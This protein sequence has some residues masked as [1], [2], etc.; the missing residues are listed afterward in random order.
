[1][2]KGGESG[3]TPYEA[4]DSG[5]SKQNVKIVEIV[6]EGE[7]QGLQDGFKSVYLDNTPV[8]A[9]DD[10]YNFKNLFAESRRGTQDQTAMTGFNTSEKEIAVSKQVRK[11][12][13]LTHTITDSNVTRLRLT[14]GVQSLFHQNDQGDTYG[15]EAT[16]RVTIGDN[17]HI[18]T[19]SG[20]Y[21]SQYLRKYIF[22]DLP[23][24][25]FIVRVERINEDSTSSRLQNNTIWASYTEIID[26]DFS[27]P[28]TALA[29]IK[30]D[31]DYFSSVPSRTYDV[32]GI[33]VRVP[34]NYNPHTRQYDGIWDGTFKTEWTNNPAWILYDVVTSKRYGLGQRLGDFGVDKWALYQA[35]QYCDQIVPDGFG[36]EE[37]RFVCNAWITD[38]KSA[39]NL[40]N[41]ICSIFRAMP[42]WNGREL[43][44][45]MDRPTDPVWTY[46]NANVIDGEFTYTYS[47]LKSRHNAIHVEWSDPTNNYQKTIEY[48]SDDDLI[49]RNGLNVK[50]VKAFGCTS[51]GQA[52]RTGLWILQTEKLETKTVTF[53]VGTEGLMHIP[54]DIIKVADVS[55]AGTDIGGRVSAVNGKVVT[56]DREIEIT[57]NSYFSYIDNSARPRDIKIESVNGHQITLENEPTGLQDLG[58][59]SLTTQTIKPQLFKALTIS[60]EEK[61]KYSILA[62]QHEPQKENIVDNGVIFSA[63]EDTLHRTPTVDN[64]AINVNQGSATVTADT[65]NGS[66][67]AQYDIRIYKDGQLYDT[68][69]GQKSP[70]AKLDNLANGDYSVTI[71][72]KNDDGQVLNTKT[73]DFVIDKPPRPT[74]VEITNGLKNVVLE[75]QYVDDTTETE[76]FVSETDDIKT[77]EK[78]AKVTA[79]MYSHEVGANKIRY[80]WLRHTRGINNGEFYKNAGLKAQTSVDIDDEIDVLK[81]AFNY[82]KLIN[83]EIEHRKAGEKILNSKITTEATQRQQALLV[84][85]Q[86]FGTK[87]TAVETAT[88]EQSQ[89]LARL[90]AVKNNLVAGLEQERAARIAGDNA[91]A[92]ARQTLVSQVNT[93]KAGISTLSQTVANNQQSAASQLTTL[94]AKVDNIEVGARNYFLNSKAPLSAYGSRIRYKRNWLSETIKRGT[95]VVVQ[96]KAKCDKD[97]VGYSQYFNT[98]NSYQAFDKKLSTKWQVLTLKRVLTGN[99]T[100]DNTTFHLQASVAVNPEI[101]W[102]KVSV[103]D[104]ATD[105]TPAPEDLKNEVTAEISSFKE[106]QA[107][108]NSAFTNQLTTL[109]AKVENFNPDNLVRTNL[110]LT[111]LDEN[112]WYP[113]VSSRLGCVAKYFFRVSKELVAQSHRTSWGSDYGFS[114]LCQWTT[115]GCG[116]GVIDVQR[117]I[118]E[119]TF[120]S[121][122]DNKSPILKLSQMEISSQEVFYL[123]GGETYWIDTEKNV[124]VTLHPSGYSNRDDAY[125]QTVM[126]ISYRSEWAPVTLAKKVSS[127]YT[128]KT[129]AIAG[130]RKAIAGITLGSSIDG[131]AVE[132]SV[133][134]LANNF[135]VAASENG[136]L[137]PLFTVQEEKAVLAPA[138]IA[139]GGITTSHLAANAVSADKISS[140]AITADKLSVSK[141]SALSSNLGDITAGSI[142][143]G[144]GK[145][146][147]NSSGQVSIK[148]AGKDVGLV[149]DSERITVYDTNGKIR[150]RMGK[151]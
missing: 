20:K 80:Y 89:Q 36:G 141:L 84:Q 146:K 66:G 3:H 1:M 46:T 34:S 127:T 98:D 75:W 118:E 86:Q 91:E 105:W 123:R 22:T 126:P 14:L 138:L 5:R 4:K 25:P 13:P 68:K 135:N 112:T 43:T 87:I 72:A 97:N 132:S 60:E 114:M 57:D 95:S 27:Y 151:L 24:T 82:D 52:H 142:D 90:T 100:P 54:G 30:F 19:I 2:G 93:N 47:A 63:Q 18:I 37:P 131:Q 49:R 28:N 23:E 149:I 103:G 113:V 119:F 7:I 139:K 64:V 125:K 133:N 136:E 16:F 51:R 45:V 65:S 59:W 15:S 115:N 70:T 79:Q 61:G 69:L 42:V 33:K 74:A 40:I 117:N 85:A 26:T 145:F 106:T 62:L 150:V 58:V 29:G 122:K 39:Y 124:S 76:I 94:T 147:V 121:V 9:S 96:I 83:D 88:N 99:L 144:N 109:T 120:K 71:V 116:W 137:Q 148:G 77:A 11:K 12:T 128:L 35:G 31:S 44:I 102:I 32:Y 92:Q 6:S 129:Q 101:E 67:T 38:Q 107:T 130:N 73:N 53:K 111:N 48:V 21:S 104:V 41:D 78:L 10:S 110:D 134:V 108:Q 8:Q 81:S 50:K 143:I 55:Y 17:S 140:G 56:L